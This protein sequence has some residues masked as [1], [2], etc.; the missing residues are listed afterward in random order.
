[1]KQGTT[2]MGEA[3][4][5]KHKSDLGSRMLFKSI[6]MR[7]PPKKFHS[8]GFVWR[9]RKWNLAPLLVRENVNTQNSTPSVH[10]K[11]IVLNLSE[12]II[13]HNITVSLAPTELHCWKFYSARFTGSEASNPP[14][15]DQRH[16]RRRDLR[17]KLSL[18]GNKH[19]QKSINECHD[20]LVW[21]IAKEGG[22]HRASANT[23]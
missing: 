23:L 16:G 15:I 20:P 1:M 11:I 10:N 7:K 13:T 18:R 9:N 14:I 22:P 12:K 8:L 19:F 17:H 6:W 5:K 3:C 2:K 21:A 4:K